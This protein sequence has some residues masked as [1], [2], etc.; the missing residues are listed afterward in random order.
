M[1]AIRLRRT[2][3]KKRP[4]FRVVV[5][6]SRTARDSRFVEVLGH[7]NPRTKPETLKLD[8]ER[9]DALGQDRARSRPTPS[10]RWSAR[11]PPR[12]Q[13]APASSSPRREPG[14]RR[15][16]SRGAGA[17]R[18]SGRRPRDRARARGP[19]ARRAVHGA[20]RSRAR[21]RTPG[22]D[23]RGDAHAG[24]R[25]RGA[26]GDQGDARVPR[27]AVA[28]TRRGSASSEAPM[29]SDDFVVGR[30]ARPHGNPRP[31]HR[32]PDTDFPEQRFRVGGGPAGG[33]SGCRAG[34]DGGFS[35]VRFHQGRP[36]LEL[37][38]IETMTEAESA[39]GRRN[40]DFPR[41]RLGRAAGGHVS[42]SRAGRLRGARHGGCAAG[43]CQRGGRADGAQPAGG[44]RAARRDPDP[45]DG[46]HLC[47]H[48]PGGA[49]D[50]GRIRRRG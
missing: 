20:G 43:P 30:V 29:A 44:R 4:F 13:P 22:P 21:H 23:R 7:Y 35:T 40:F 27:P 37:E 50:R 26:R 14:A 12:R 10:G 3:S 18:S 2:G 39:G 6:D 1:L 19:D 32:E 38:G 34:P 28:A 9:L 25:D 41:Q 24:R 42:P 16:R 8:R 11:M 33:A 36:I 49:A 17:G 31:G 47:Q 48:R 45:A 15:R 46:R 5:T